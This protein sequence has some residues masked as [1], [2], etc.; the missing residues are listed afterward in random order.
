MNQHTEI[1]EKIR[2]SN[3]KDL[4][5]GIAYHGVRPNKNSDELV[6]LVHAAKS[7][8]INVEVPNCTPC[9]D[10]IMNFAKEVDFYC[11]ENNW[12]V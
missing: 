5:Q 8:G 12:E 2:L 1:F 4:I 3:Y 7:H 10:I 11:R 6:G 9:N